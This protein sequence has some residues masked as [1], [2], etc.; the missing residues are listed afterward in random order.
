MRRLLVTITLCIAAPAAADGELVIVGPVAIGNAQ[1]AHV[2]HIKRALDTAKLAP[3]ERVVSAECVADPACLHDVGIEL[4]AKRL[5]AIATSG[6]TKGGV[7]L[8]FQLVDITGKELVSHRDVAIADRRLTNDLGPALKKFLDAAPVEHAKALFAE[9]N[10]HYNLGEFAP[11]LELYKRAYR[12]KPLAAFQFNI[13]QCYRKL[14]QHQEAINMYQAYLAEVPE[15]QNKPLVES[16]I[17]ESQDKL[18]AE[19]EAAGKLAEEQA[20]LEEVRIAAEKKKIE[21]ERKA[22]EAEALAEME[23]H[24]Q[25]LAAIEREREREKLYDLHP[26]RKWAYVAGGLGVASLVAGGAW[27]LSVRNAQ[28]A[29]DDGGCGDPNRV[30]GASALALCQQERDRGKRDALYATV[31][32]AGG[33]ALAATAVALFAIDP[34][35]IERPGTHV[36]IAPGSIQMM[37][38]W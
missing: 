1:P 31:S 2:R 18:A 16:L 11:A 5:L 14:G 20:H 10:Q 7:A 24:R 27:G 32:L 4:G 21:D 34:G 36:A 22:K 9:G 23:R 13:A 33:A 17:K 30:L 19:H 29:F 15:A 28:S 26:A 8:S 6:D 37:V 38:R 12:A 3:S 25:Q 35:N